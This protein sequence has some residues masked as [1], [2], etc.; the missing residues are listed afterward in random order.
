MVWL[1]ARRSTWSWGTRGW[2]I[3]AVRR[4]TVAEAIAGVEVP[5]ADA[6]VLGAL[7][8]DHEGRRHIDFGDAVRK[9]KQEPVTDFPLRG[10]RSCGWLLRSIADHGGTPDGRHTKWAVEQKN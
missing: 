8:Y 3:V 10:E 9:M 6:R 1:K 4:V 5:D 7:A 2:E